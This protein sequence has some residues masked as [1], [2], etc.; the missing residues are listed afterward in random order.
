MRT[1]AAR[2]INYVGRLS[3]SIDSSVLSLKILLRILEGQNSLP[4]SSTESLPV[5]V[6]QMA[7]IY[8]A[9]GNS[10]Q[11]IF[12]SSRGKG[13]IYRP[14][15]WS[16]LQKEVENMI[17][18]LDRINITL[19][20]LIQ[21]ATVIV[22]ESIL[23][24]IQCPREQLG[25]L[26]LDLNSEVIPRSQLHGS[27]TPSVAGS[28]QTSLPPDGDSLERFM[29]RLTRQEA[30]YFTL[31]NSEE[32][33]NYTL[34]HLRV[35]LDGNNQVHCPETPSHLVLVRRH[36]CNSVGRRLFSEA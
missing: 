6:T 28:A 27:R 8:T 5:V 7:E 19:S 20:L 9:I 26:D 17:E 21:L 33:I 25:V 35:S 15:R 14:L 12:G 29:K 22:S 1:F 13:A 3:R 24:N 23:D 16:I 32:G 2:P 4:R 18:T 31:M 11:K 36:S 10:F 34:T 30:R